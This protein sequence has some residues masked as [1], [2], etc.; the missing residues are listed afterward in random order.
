MAI[1]I[2][3]IE[4]CFHVVLFITAYN[5][6]ES[7]TLVSAGPFQ[8]KL[9]SSNL[10]WGY[11]VSRL[12]SILILFVFHFKYRWGNDLTVRVFLVASPELQ[13]SYIFLYSESCI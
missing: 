8:R 13:V 4:Q 7:E 6:S 5:K 1:Q 10:M 3:A 9:S 12:P 2:K 11:L